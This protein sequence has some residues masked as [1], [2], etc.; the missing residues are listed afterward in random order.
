[1]DVEGSLGKMGISRDASKRKP[2]GSGSVQW[3]L[4]PSLPAEP[5]H[6]RKTL[7]RFFARFRPSF[8]HSHSK[9]TSA[10]SVHNGRMVA[11]ETD[12]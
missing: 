7:R 8:A 11:I 2:R 9:N 4:L 3:N 10:F 12:E 6:R 1:M 5:A